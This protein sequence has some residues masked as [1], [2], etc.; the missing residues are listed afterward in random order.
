SPLPVAMETDGSR[1]TVQ[2]LGGAFTVSQSDFSQMVA[3]VGDQGSGAEPA[4]RGLQAALNLLY[5]FRPGARRAFILV[6][7]EADF[8]YAYLA[9]RDPGTGIL[10]ETARMMAQAAAAVYVVGPPGQDYAGTPTNHFWDATAGPYPEAYGIVPATGGLFQDINTGDWGA[11]LSVLGLDIAKLTAQGVT[12]TDPLPAG[13]SFFS[14]LPPPSLVS[15]QDVVWSLGNLGAG[16]SLTL[17]L[18]AVLSGVQGSEVLH[19]GASVSASNALGGTSPDAAVTVLSATWTLTHTY[20]HTPTL[21]PTL[22]PS[23]SWTVTRTYSPIPTL[24]GTDT[25]Q[26]TLSRSPTYT[27]FPSLTPTVSATKTQSL[28]FTYTAQSSK[29]GTV[30]ATG[31][32]SATVSGRAS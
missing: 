29:T 26:A 18:T 12:L 30:S 6:T 16:M 17:T 27:L 21:T 32:S 23:A 24:T 9:D 22:S 1:H 4:F 13:S 3:S 20:T 15:G 19:N 11:L 28:T 10:A 14:S 5:E 8:D 31:T 2:D 25:V 7:D